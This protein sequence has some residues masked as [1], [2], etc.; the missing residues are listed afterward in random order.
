MGTNY[1]AIQKVSKEQ[2]KELHKLID[3][4]LFVELI[5]PLP[6]QVHLG[7]SSSG[8]EFCWNHNGWKHYKNK[9]ELIS[10]LKNSLIMDEYDKEISFKDFWRQTQKENRRRGDG[11][12]VI[13]NKEYF[14]NW[15][16]Y[17]P[18]NRDS[19][20]AREMVSKGNFHEEYHFGMRFSDTTEF[21]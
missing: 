9:K 12:E 14:T 16:K 18:D 6:K 17:H 20:Y 13:N 2:K 3:E 5:D 7:K 11:S 8:W 15:T 10:F 1:Y 19:D 4:E 21:C